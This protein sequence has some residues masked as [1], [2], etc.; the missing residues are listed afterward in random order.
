MIDDERAL[1]DGFELYFA[2]TPADADD[3]LAACKWIEE[4]FLGA[5]ENSDSTTE[6]TDSTERAD[7]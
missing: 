3:R 6:N 7:G 5:T 1:I 2:R 4:R